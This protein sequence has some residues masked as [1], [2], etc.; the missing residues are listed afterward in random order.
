MKVWTIYRAHCTQCGQ[1]KEFQSER[2]ARSYINEHQRGHDNPPINWT[3]P[4]NVEEPCG[5]A[6]EY[7]DRNRYHRFRPPETENVE[8]PK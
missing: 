2:A 5:W 6:A 7:E 3:T 4:E 1:V 8:E